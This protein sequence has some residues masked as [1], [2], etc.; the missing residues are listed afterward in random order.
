MPLEVLEVKSDVV[1]IS[2]F[3]LFLNSFA[4]NMSKES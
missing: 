1:S 4:R 3:L 2:I